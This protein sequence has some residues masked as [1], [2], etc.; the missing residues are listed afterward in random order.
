MRPYILLIAAIAACAPENVDGGPAEQAAYVPVEFEVRVEAPSGAEVALI[1]LRFD[2][3]GGLLWAGS[4]F[5]T[6]IIEGGLA[7][8]ELPSSAPAKDRDP[9]GRKVTVTYGVFALAPNAEGTDTEYVAVGNDLL[10]YVSAERAEV[11]EGW[12][13]LVADDAG[14][15]EYG[16]IAAGLT[17]DASMEPTREMTITGALGSQLVPGEDPFQLGFFDVHGRQSAASAE[18]TGTWTVSFNELTVGTAV[19]TLGFP[20]VNLIPG[21]FIDLDHSGQWSQSDE[22]VATVCAGISELSV[23]KV[24]TPTNPAA[25][26][27]IHK[28]GMAVGWGLYSDRATGLHQLL[29]EEAG[30][31]MLHADCAAP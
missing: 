6:A 18:V 16:D 1:P 3:A 27:A 9:E 28:A 15:V 23:F 19:H 10:G 13:L 24:E 11:E 2:D 14:G 29:G 30:G 5:A 22:V 4:P 26:W 17:L 12:Y 21:V 20:M 7:H 25:A 8:F 31:F